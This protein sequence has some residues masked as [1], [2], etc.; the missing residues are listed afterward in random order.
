M[1]IDSYKLTERGT[2]A[3]IRLISLTNRFLFGRLRNIGYDAETCYVII[4]F[5]R[6]IAKSYLLT[7]R[8]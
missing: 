7:S 6:S 1:R 8:K 5:T 4:I 3:D 2:I